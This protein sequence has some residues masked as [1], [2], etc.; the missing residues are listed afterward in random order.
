MAVT[1]LLRQWD[2]LQ[3]VLLPTLLASRPAGAVTAWN[4]APVDDALALALAARQVISDLGGPA[5][6][7]VCHSAL[8]LPPEPVEWSAGELRGLACL[9]WLEPVAGHR[10]RRRPPR[11]VLEA[12]KLG[13]PPDAPDLVVGRL[14]RLLEDPS[15]GR[16][17]DA[18]RRDGYVLLVE[19]QPPGG[20][21]A[22]HFE[23]ADDAGRLFRKVTEAD[24]RAIPP[25]VAEPLP[26]LASHQE[27]LD[28]IIGYTNLARSLARRF[29]GRGERSEDLEQ[30]AMLALVRAAG[31]YDPAMGRPFAAFATP[32][33]IGELKRHFR[34]RSWMVRV[35][36]S[37][38]EMNLAIRGARD[39]LTQELGASPTIAQMANRLGTNDED[40]L[41]VMEVVSTC[42]P[43]SLDANPTPEESPVEIAVTD[44]GFDGVLDDR[45]LQEAV[46]RLEPTEA[47]IIKRAFFDNCTQRAIA[48]ELGLSQ[49]Q[50]SR[51]MR[52]AI[53]SMRSDFE[54]T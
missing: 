36:R 16:P 12:V 23:P 45:V 9:E 33:I 39:E 35:P 15:G 20:L 8:P 53:V 49:M 41:N 28:L 27:R 21:R 18:L 37:V 46:R 7:Q 24:P 2:F 42:W 34:D 10:A 13:P 22:D 3:T 4:V 29:A 19:P 54:L 40:V 17:L 44:V 47:Y 1:A 30:V 38:Q 6:M 25:P 11:D 31:R 32:T 50:V 52:K 48:R 51:M 43:T 14:P 26:C 5:R